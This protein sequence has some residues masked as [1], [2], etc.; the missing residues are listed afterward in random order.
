MPQNIFEK[1]IN[2]KF[3]ENLSSGGRI[4]YFVQ[5]IGREKGQMDMTKLIVAFYNFAN[6]SKSWLN[7][8]LWLKILPVI[9]ENFQPWS[10]Q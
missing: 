8:S 6:S 2:V 5:N 10:F 9:I 3:D 1:Y 7:L 4:V